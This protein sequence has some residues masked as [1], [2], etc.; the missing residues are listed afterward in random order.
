[1]PGFR[2]GPMVIYE[3]GKKSI[4]FLVL[5]FQQRII[6][7]IY[8]FQNLACNFSDTPVPIFQ[9]RKKAINFSM[10]L[11]LQGEYFPFIVLSLDVEG[12]SRGLI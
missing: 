8:H 10:V 9:N 1:M 11:S 12:S 3:T 6:L 7:G 5:S 2:D 4:H